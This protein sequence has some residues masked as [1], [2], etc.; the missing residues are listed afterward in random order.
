[1][2]IY[3]VL[4]PQEIQQYKNQG[5]TEADMQT[6]LNETTGVSSGQS[7]LQQSYD[8]T[9]FQAKQDP[10]KLASYSYITGAAN[11]NLIQWQLELDTILERI[12]HMLRG[13]KPTYVQGSLIWKSPEKTK[14][15]EDQQIFNEEGVNEI[16]RVLSMYL[17]R[18]TILSNYDEKTIDDKM[19]DLGNEL[20]DLIFLKYEAFGL[21]T[22]EKRKLYPIIIRQLVDIVHSSYLRALHGGERESLRETRQVS[23][24]EAL[25][26]GININTMPM[27]KERGILN[28]MRWVRGKY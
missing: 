28:P 5:Y 27:K 22:L 6:A 4:S 25:Q 24:T 9:K 17:N 1:M 11:E 15:G 14:E 8:K 23:Q 2:N 12:E 10:R 19:F 3:E 18:N 16:M 21:N 13:D 7:V 26:G 20:A